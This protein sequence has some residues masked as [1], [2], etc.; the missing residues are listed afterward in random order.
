MVRKQYRCESCGM[1]F[2]HEPEAQIHT[3][4]CQGGT[5]YENL[6]NIQ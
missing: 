1:A 2:V 5:N 3:L 4:D 6:D